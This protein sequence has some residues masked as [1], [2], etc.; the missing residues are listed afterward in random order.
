MIRPLLIALLLITPGLLAASPQA[1]TPPIS[2]YKAHFKA[3][4]A[5]FKMGEIERSL[6]K[7]DN[8]LFEQTSLIYSTGLLSVFRP[9]RFE[10][11]SYWRW[12]DNGPV[13]ERYTYHFSGNKGDVYEQLEFDWQ[14]MQVHSLR[15]GKTTTLE[16]EKGVVD[17]LSYQIALVRDLRAGKK[18][19]FYKVADRGDI[20]HIRYKV[21]GEEEIETPWGKQHTLKVQ[22][23]TL[24]KERITILWFAPDLDYMV[25][26]L[27][28]DDNGT[29]MS[30]TITDLTIEGMN[31]VK[32]REESPQPFIW[33]ND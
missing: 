5:G 24:T 31:L 2:S 21:V 3:E 15:E 1:E 25:I 4:V 28:Q 16:I 29:K 9:D 13:P 10:E 22:R 30:A 32:A 20:R 26:K 19:F 18:E 7:H 14:N 11:H 6:K 17:K 12:Q 27:V 23:Q 33:T 8:G